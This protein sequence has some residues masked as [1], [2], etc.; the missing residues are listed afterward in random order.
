[1]K[2]QKRHQN[3]IVA[4]KTTLTL[5]ILLM[6]LLLVLPAYAG[7]QDRGN[8]PDRPDPGKKYGKEA[9][10]GQI[11]KETRGRSALHSRGMEMRQLRGRAAGKA[12]STL[13][14]AKA[15]SRNDWKNMEKIP[16]TGLFL[17]DLD[18]VPPGLEKDLEENGYK[19]AKDGT[20]T[21]NGNPVAL[22]VVG[23]TYHVK[24]S[25]PPTDKR[26]GEG[27]AE[28]AVDVLFQLAHSVD[29]LITTDVEAASPFPWRCF[30]WSFR[31]EYDGGFCREYK[32]WSRAYA[33][34][35][36]SD[37]ACANPKPLTRIEYISTY[38]N[39]S[40]R[41][42]WDY[43]YNADQSHSYAKWD[44]GCFWPAHGSGSGYHYAYWRD[45]SAWAYRTWS[46]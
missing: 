6:G 34:G 41:T 14:G 29:S 2:R 36:G 9:N 3:A 28:R 24:P 46:W 20:L 7:P 23:E 44:I 37:G 17:I 8:Q 26:G 35:P 43:H 33:W 5:T 25:G 12:V 42:D 39:N 10:P 21:K 22:F 45:G 31:W 16:K 15:I 11:F 27:L 19:L 38:V 13:P 40:G 18:H 1:M 4:G 30:S 32:A